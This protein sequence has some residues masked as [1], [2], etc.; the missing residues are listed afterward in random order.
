MLRHENILGK[1]EDNPFT[2]LSR[3]KELPAFAL[4]DLVD[5]NLQVSPEKW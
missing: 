3:K 4:S 2:I 5:V 1:Y